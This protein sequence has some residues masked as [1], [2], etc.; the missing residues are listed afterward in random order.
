MMELT[1]NEQIYGFNFGIGFLKEINK[2]VTMPDESVPKKM[3]EVGFKYYV[4]EMLDDDV[5]ALIEILKT[6]NVGTEPR[7]TEK[8]LSDYIDDESTD[9][10]GLFE[11]VQDFLSKANAT[12][13][14]FR[15]IQKAYEEQMEAEEE[16]KMAAKAMRDAMLP[17]E[18]T[19]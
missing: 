10:D 6:A 15:K 3:K 5:L 8:M 2:K 16:Q 11:E 17:K 19:S 14:D 1:I 4:A 18:Q 7:V 9:L 12:K 13:K